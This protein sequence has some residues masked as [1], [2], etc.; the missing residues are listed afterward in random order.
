MVQVA[1]KRAHLQISGRVQGVFFRAW[2]A[3]SARRL[4]LAGWVRNRFDGSVEAVFEGPAGKVDEMVERC[5]RGPDHARVDS[6]LDDYGEPVEG[7]SGF[8]VR[9]SA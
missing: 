1:V 7:L 5:R 3:E 9:S 6:I 4:G 2:T 8:E